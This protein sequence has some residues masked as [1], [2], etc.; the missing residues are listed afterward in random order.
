MISGPVAAMPSQKDAI[1][2]HY[3]LASPIYL[4]D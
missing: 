4:L 1:P 2:S 3:D